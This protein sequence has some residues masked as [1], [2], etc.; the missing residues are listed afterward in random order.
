MPTRRSLLL[1]GACLLFFPFCKGPQRAQPGEA[2]VVET[3]SIFQHIF[4]NRLA[5]VQVQRP[6]GFAGVEPDQKDQRFSLVPVYYATDRLPSGKKD[7][8]QFFTGNPN[9]WGLQFGKCIVTV[10]RIHELGELERPTW[11]KLEFSEKADRHMVLKEVV[12]SQEKDF[13]HDLRW[14]GLQADRREALVF[15][16]GFN[17]S[18]DE[19]ALRAAQIAYDVSFQGVPILYSWPS[20]GS[21]VEYFEDGKKNAGT[22]PNLERFLKKLAREGGF[23]QIHIVAHSMGNRALTQ[24]LVNLAQEDPGHRL[25]G[26]VILAAPDVDAKAFVQDIAPLIYQTAQNVTLYASAKDKA[27]LLSKNINSGPRAGEGGKN[28]VVVD[29][30]ETVDASLID[31]DFLGHNYF[32]NTWLLINDLYYLIN[33]GWQADRRFLLVEQK[34]RWRYWF[35]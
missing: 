11:W 28:L 26:Q 14:A 34:D 10:P 6:K 8:Y 16:H 7:P 22:V 32:A 2:P 27:L 4:E 1:F 19:G 31:T 13:F 12:P 21:I 9:P 18:F 30:I 33:R 17:V 20:Q 24:A 23:D 15:I 25:F 35:F 3:D 5:E 29:H